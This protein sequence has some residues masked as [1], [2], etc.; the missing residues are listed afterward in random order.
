MTTRCYAWPLTV[1]DGDDLHLH[2]STGY[3]R[4]GVRLLRCG[5]GVTAADGPPGSYAGQPVP[6]GRPDEAW[7]WP[8]YRIPLPASLADGI[9]LA[10]PVPLGAA[11]EPAPVPADPAAAARPDA[12][13]FVL[14]REPA[15]EPGRETVWFKLPTATYGAYN[16]LGGASLYAG[17][18]WARDWA[19]QGYVVSLQRPG[20]GG[21]GGRVMEGDAPDA[22]ARASRRQTFAHWD[23]PF[24][25]WL[26]RN[27]YQVRYCTDFDLHYDQAL[28]GAGG[29]LI[30]AGHDEYWS[31]EMRR[32]V[33]EFTDRGGNVCFFTGDT[34]CFEVEFPASGDRMFCR[35]M[36]GGS[37]E[38][39]GS[40][41][42]GALWP[43]NDQED[44][45]TMSSPAWGGGWWD[46]RR[47][48]EG[49]QAVVGGHWAF[50]GVEFPPGGI[51]GG[52]ATP[53]I[54]YET[55]GVRLDRRSSP[56]RLSD[57]PKGNGAGRVLL[58][59]ADLSAGWVA[60]REDANAAMML[61]TA[62]SGGMVFS[63]GTTDW[64]LAL[65]SD[66]AIGQITANVVGRLAHGSLRI[67]GPVCAESAYV[68]DGDMIGPDTDTGWYLNGDQVAALGL[69]GVEWQV[70]GGER[71]A[72][73]GAD[74]DAGGPGVPLVTRSADGQEWLTVTA[75]AQ[76]AA[77]R[78]YFGS[79]TVR[80]LDT[81]EFLRR[82]VIRALNA[83]AYP[84]EQ[85]G[86]L[87]DQ[88]AAEGELAE[89]VIPV[90]LG[91]LAEYTGVLSGLLADLEARWTISGRMAD[92]ALRPDE[93]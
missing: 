41:R 83:I 27:G 84:D 52:E 93:K 49:Y 18:R 51:T 63:V 5:A 11:G 31:R 8:S 53:V 89:R 12:C 78:R 91:W 13:L 56:P 66:P 2:V 6:L 39:S 71:A 81:D 36:A 72:G 40:D 22:Y 35:K 25:A 47:V 45:L 54:G 24:V 37:P 50:D 87:V 44:W 57:Q 43:V 69:A 55:D 48:I 62:P 75:T 74:H 60:G 21:V 29:L 82:R 46:G 90:R 30:S 42:I 3:P 20:N 76:D 64:P 28:L 7:G 68:G 88:H 86:A 77:G 70:R 33:L 16:Q 17:A 65:D 92:G 38:G 9:Y 32:Q 15:P 61:R 19:A 4:F 79:R 23:A 26:E 59:L 58:A 67:H 85:G 73:A 80:V 1:Q 10:V 34:A 14:R